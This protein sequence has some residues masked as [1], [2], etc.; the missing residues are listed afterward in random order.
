MSEVN[1]RTNVVGAIWIILGI[2]ALLGGI[3]VAVGALGMT[4]GGEI[5]LVSDNP[6][7]QVWIVPTCLII[8]PLCIFALGVISILA[9]LALRRHRPWAR[10]AIMILSIV[11]LINIPIGTAAGLYSII[12]LLRTM[13]NRNWS[14]S[15]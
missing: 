8:I 13:G 9:G 10:T 14:A 1:D 15:S 6:K 2:L 4:M 7:T 3:V 11:N 12:M 5:F